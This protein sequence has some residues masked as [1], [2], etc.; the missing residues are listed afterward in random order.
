MEVLQ[1]LT[2]PRLILSLAVV[3]CA[4]WALIEQRLTG[5]EWGVVCGAAMWW[6]GAA[7]ASAA[8]KNGGAL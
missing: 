8:P 2:R 1:Q 6:T 5:S 4:T 7:G 3:G